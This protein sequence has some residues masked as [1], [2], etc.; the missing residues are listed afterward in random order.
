MSSWLKT[1]EVELPNYCVQH[2]QLPNFHAQN[3]QLAFLRFSITKLLITPQQFPIDDIR[4]PRK[5]VKNVASAEDVATP[6]TGSLWA[7]TSN[8][9]RWVHSSGIRTVTTLLNY[10]P[11]VIGHVRS[12][13]YTYEGVIYVTLSL[14]E[15]DSS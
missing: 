13:I 9:S 11:S 6:T 3:F 7:V 12:T 5:G 14:S 15:N 8:G 2:F 1:F 4:Y 10:S